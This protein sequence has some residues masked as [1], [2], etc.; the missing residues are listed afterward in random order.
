MSWKCIYLHD[1]FI[2]YFRLNFLITLVNEFLC[3]RRRCH[4][5]F[6]LIVNLSGIFPLHSWVC[7]CDGFCFTFNLH[8]VLLTKI[9][10]VKRASICSIHFFLFP[11]LFHQIILL[12]VSCHVLFF[13]SYLL[14]FFFS[15]V[16]QAMRFFHVCSDFLKE[17]C[18]AAGGICYF[19]CY[20][21]IATYR[22]VPDI[23]KSW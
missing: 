21:M 4:R 11:I 17:N 22:H 1:D 5:F 16:H 10:A 18:N 19:A 7:V 2:S 23:C 3:F 20:L 8:V 9:I 14:V 12:I 13:F 15:F 6:R